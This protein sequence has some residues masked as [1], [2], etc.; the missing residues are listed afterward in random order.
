V[1]TVEV[2]NLFYVYSETSVAVDEK[3]LLECIKF[4]ETLLDKPAGRLA[5][6]QFFNQETGRDLVTVLLSVATPQG[7]LSTQYSTKVLHFFNK[8]FS[9]GEC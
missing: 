1:Y 5:L 4:M 8:L 9:T 3:V 7:S 6:D 2:C